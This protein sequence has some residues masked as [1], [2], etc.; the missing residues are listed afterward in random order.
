MDL[1]E[2]FRDGGDWKD[3]AKDRDQQR[4]YIRAVMYS[5]WVFLVN[6]RYQPGLHFTWNMYSLT[7]M[8][9][10]AMLIVLLCIILRVTLHH[11]DRTS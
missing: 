3:L 8:F 4:H 10:H 2:M 9:D 1:R 7:K 5:Q 11:I 6:Y